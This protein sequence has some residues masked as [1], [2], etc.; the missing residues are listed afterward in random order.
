MNS[1]SLRIDE[2]YLP[3]YGIKLLAGRNFTAQ[4]ASDSLHPVLLNERAVRRLGWKDNVALGKPIVMN[5]VNAMV[6]GVVNDFN[7]NTL[8]EATGPVILYPLD[9]HFSQITF[10]V[11]TAMTSR[12]VALIGQVW[13][14]HF[15]DILFD[16]GFVSEEVKAQYVAEERFSN[17]FL[18][19]SLLSLV[20][21]GVGLYGLTSYA[22]AQR[23]KEIGIR[24][25]LG[26]SIGNMTLMLAWDILKLV[27]IACIISVPIASYSMNSWLQGFAYRVA[28]PWWIFAAAGSLVI[29]MSLSTVA[30]RIIKASMANPITSLRSE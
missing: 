8:E 6:V 12:A 11:N 29:L 22:M 25:V 23:T 24:K 19:F 5:G 27:L 20:I 7:Y 21:A 9:N 1:A 2:D 13:K 3:V 10:R 18:A 16:Y 30:A 15:P 26:A 17:I 4:S 14:K 28:V